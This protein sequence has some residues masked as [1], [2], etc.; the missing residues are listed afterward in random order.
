[1][2]LRDVMA[3]LQKQSADTPDT[4]QEI[5]GYQR[6]ASIYAGCTPDTPDTLRFGDTQEKAQFVPV[7]EASNDPEPPTA[8][9]AP[10]PAR[11]PTGERYREWAQTWRP[12]AD[13]YHKHHFSCPTCIAAGKG[14]G[15]RCGV[16]AALWAIYT[17]H[18]AGDPP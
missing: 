10:A 11:K 13:A 2:A 16:G 5:M 9:P 7:D 17:E 18:S 4:S 12:L 14:Y 15:L 6:K 8:S 3:Y 1:M